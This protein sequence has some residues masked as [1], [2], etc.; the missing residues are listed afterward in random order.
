MTGSNKR[1]RQLCQLRLGDRA[2]GSRKLLRERKRRNAE[3]CACG[4]PRRRATGGTFG[5]IRQVDCGPGDGRVYLEPR[6]RALTTL[7]PKA[8]L[9]LT[10]PH[11]DAQDED[12]GQADP[13]GS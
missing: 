11:S 8:A 4:R 1:P 3:T 13:H 9:S 10:A 5:V 12:E 7:R 2:D 6:S